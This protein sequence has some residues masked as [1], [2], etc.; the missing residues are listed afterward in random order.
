V[1]NQ[2][3]SLRLPTLA[4]LVIA[5]R[6]CL[7]IPNDDFDSL[8]PREDSDVDSSVGSDAPLAGSGGGG[9]VLPDTAPEDSAGSGGTEADSSSDGDGETDAGP[10][11][12]ASETGND[13][14]TGGSPPFTTAPQLITAPKE[15]GVL[16]FGR[17][18]AISYEWALIGADDPTGRGFAYF[19]HRSTDGRWS[20]RQQ[21]STL[22]FPLRDANFGFSVAISGAFAVVGAPG[23]PARFGEAYYFTLD[24][25]E[26]VLMRPPESARTGLP[27]DR[28]GFDVDVDLKAIVIGAPGE[29]GGLGAVYV[30]GLGE[31]VPYPGT[32]RSWVR[33]GSPEPSSREFG[34]GVEIEGET[35]VACSP[36]RDGLQ[37]GAYVFGLEGE[38]WVYRQ[39]LLPPSPTDE[40]FCANGMALHGDT[41][42][43]GMSS[44]ATGGAVHI[45]TRNSRGIWSASPGRIT[46]P[47][48]VVKNVW[49]F[50]SR[51]A[52]CGDHAVIGH[53]TPA[54][55]D[56][57]VLFYRKDQS[58]WN[59]LGAFS[60]VVSGAV[61]ASFTCYEAAMAVG[62]RAANA[63]S[64][65]VHF[66][67][68]K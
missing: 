35:L 3:R 66:F 45:F 33:L 36:G 16:D 49:R 9:G 6:G 2:A 29:S 20:L 37:G 56:S 4:A 34:A 10:D 5:T 32:P 1:W 60:Q 26:W 40:T 44:P 43:L 38:N 7:L 58:A 62:D 67:D 52:L 17:S 65:G 23:T 63:R 57:D 31:Y 21:V 64:G 41:L 50:G 27:N 55:Q 39:K 68:L 19:A 24:G 61:F 14:E 15:D 28:F 18:V 59:V 22:D 53:Q 25:E 11:D 12:A 46:A 42:L 51:T 30:Q 54:T 13:A 8:L 47:V 48:D